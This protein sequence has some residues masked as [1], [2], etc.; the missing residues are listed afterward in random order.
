MPAKAFE[1]TFVDPIG[2]GGSLGRLIKL[3]ETDPHNCPLFHTPAATKSEIAEQLKK[4]HNIEIDRRKINLQDPIKA[5]GTYL[6]EVKLYPEITGQIRVV[7][8][9]K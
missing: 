3:S 5:F 4:Q 9:D 2:R 1:V 6:P 8:T 7:V